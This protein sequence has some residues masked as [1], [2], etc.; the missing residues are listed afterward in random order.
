M[1]LRTWSN[2][3]DRRRQDKWRSSYVAPLYVSSAVAVAMYGLL[4]TGW[5]F[6]TLSLTFA[7]VLLGLGM[8]SFVA[9]R[10]DRAASLPGKG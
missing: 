5:Q 1:G 7:A 6:R 9:R 2:R 3:L 10:R 4:V 8:A